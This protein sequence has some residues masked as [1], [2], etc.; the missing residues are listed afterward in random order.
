MERFGYINRFTYKNPKILAM[1]RVRAIIKR[2]GRAAADFPPC[3]PSEMRFP[4]QLA[5]LTKALP[6][7]SF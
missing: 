3:S 7:V 6:E 5:V 2:R 4:L 1:A